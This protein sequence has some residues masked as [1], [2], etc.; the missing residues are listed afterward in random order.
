[1]KFS[2]ELL[3]GTAEL[4]VLQI[5]AKNGE[6]Y[7]YELVRSIAETSNNVFEFQEGTLYPLLYRLEARGFVVSTK[8]VAD[9]GK[10]RRYYSITTSGT[11]A[12]KDRRAELGAF[13]QG[14][15]AALDLA[16]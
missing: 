9:S 15:S 10:E 4:L 12:L 13:V 11:A 2:S 14:L 7:G 1:M 6:S 5:L 16:V 8:K 3:K